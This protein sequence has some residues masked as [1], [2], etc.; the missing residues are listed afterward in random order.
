MARKGRNQRMAMEFFA[1]FLRS[2]VAMEKDAFAQSIAAACID[3][4]SQMLAD[5]NNCDELWEGR[6]PVLGPFELWD[7]FSRSRVFQK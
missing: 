5:L 2:I 4:I 6:F 7:T 1:S 3:W